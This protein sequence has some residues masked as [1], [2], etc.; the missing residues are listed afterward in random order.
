MGASVDA[1]WPAR[2]TLAQR[3]HALAARSGAL[4]ILDP[5][6]YFLNGENPPLHAWS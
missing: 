5:R 2:S 3:P 4:E 6:Q 1:D